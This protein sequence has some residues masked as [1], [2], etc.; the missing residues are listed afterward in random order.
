MLL[1]FDLPAAPSR[2][3]SLSVSPHTDGPCLPVLWICRPPLVTAL[4]AGHSKELVSLLL[5]PCVK[6]RPRGVD[7]ASP[8]DGATAVCLA[9]RNNRAD[10]LGQASWHVADGLPAC[11]CQAVPA[12]ATFPSA[13]LCWLA[14]RCWLVPRALWLSPAALYAM[15]FPA[16][17]QAL[18]A[19]E[20]DGGRQGLDPPL[21]RPG[22]GPCRH[23]AAAA[24]ACEEEQTGGR[25]WGEQGARTGSEGPASLHQLATGKAR[26]AMLCCVSCH[27]VSLGVVHIFG[28][29]VPGMCHQT[30]P[31]V[32]CVFATRPVCPTELAEYVN[33]LCEG[34]TALHR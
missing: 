21:L 18:H 25:R 14:N 22:S 3:T 16:A 34:S 19:L 29:P 30:T 4:Q 23:G 6:Y 12:P 32:A 10:V 13:L 20:H 9:L 5:D 26:F 33:E 1:P 8:T 24:G 15:C 2:Q 31:R 7:E 11:R 28:A 17:A 27:F